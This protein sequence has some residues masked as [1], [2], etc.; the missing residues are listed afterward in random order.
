VIVVAAGIVPFP[1]HGCCG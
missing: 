1:R